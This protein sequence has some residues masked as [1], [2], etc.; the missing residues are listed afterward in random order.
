MAR[1]PNLPKP[2][3]VDTEHSPHAELKPV[4][5]AAVTLTNG[6]WAPRLAINREITLPAQY[7]Q[8]ESTG[9][10][11]NFRRAAGKLDIDFQGRYYN[12]SDVYKWVEAAAWSLAA[13]EDPALKDML[14]GVVH[15]IA[16]AQEP[17]GYLNTYFSFDR[18]PE[19]WSNLRDMHELYCAGHLFHAAVAH[20]RTTG[21]TRLLDAARRFADLICD[22]FGSG[23]AQRPGVAGH[24][25]IEMA[26]VE[27]ARTTG[28]VRYLAQAVYFVDARG[29]G[30]LGNSAYHQDHQPLRE[31]GRL[32]GHAV[33]AAYLVAGAADVLAE[34]GEPALGEALTRLW[35][36]M[37]A[38]QMYVTGGLGS[39]HRGEAIGA[40]HE[41]PN[42]LAY[43]E[44]CAGIANVMWA[45]RMLQLHGDAGYA[46]LMERALYNAVLPGISLAGTTY[47]YVNPL[48]TDGQAEPGGQIYQ[49]QPWFGT[50]CCPT[51]IS[52]TLAA[53][54]GMLYSV[55]GRTVWVHHYAANEAQLTLPD[56]RQLHIVQR[57]RY[58]WDGL[59]TIEILTEGTF[60]LKVRIPGWCDAQEERF[61]PTININSAPYT[62]E[63]QPSHY[64]TIEHNWSVGDALCIRM[65]MAIRRIAAHPYILENTGRTALVRGPLLYC[66]EGMDHPQHDL[67]DIIL[68]P[69]GA[70]TST[71]HTDLLGGVQV[72]EG[73]ASAVTIDAA[74]TASPYRAVEP[75]KGAM[76]ALELTA[77]PY[78]AWANREPG[79][80]QIWLRR[81]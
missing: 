51:N 18:A 5:L 37:H 44:T 58:P 28:D 75:P 21:K 62:G 15:L 38:R 27:L 43:A 35:Q 68:P 66:L 16:E 40:D 74:W 65:P 54:P 79:A 64:V 80:L 12:D 56:G 11:D 53:F 55:T 3:I 63:V 25:E 1:M 76:S 39:R 22:T 47:F 20:Y 45:W 26:L 67:R 73:T 81:S 14:E 10:L 23:Q 52:R 60:T 59:V 78:F 4:P 46:D 71:F 57:T 9:R 8:L 34:T 7:Q 31:T 19:R 30:L 36:H 17:D 69:G 41:L 24:P 13:T 49:R 50:A 33:R 70:L 72:I 2:Y 77:I 29:H 32:T 48:A 42:A 61:R 6:F